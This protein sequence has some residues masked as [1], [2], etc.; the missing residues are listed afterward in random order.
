MKNYRRRILLSLEIK[1]KTG[2]KKK[3]ESTTLG[4]WFIDINVVERDIKVFYVAISKKK[5][6]LSI[7]Y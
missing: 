7:I 2:N 4:K 1:Q 6:S 5:L 3:R